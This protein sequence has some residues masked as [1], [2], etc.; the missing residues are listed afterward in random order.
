MS[1]EQE[2]A[3]IETTTKNQAPK[4]KRQL[5]MMVLVALLGLAVIGVLVWREYAAK[6]ISTDNAKVA[7]EIIDVS[8]KVT[9]RLD[10]ILV[11][12][13]QHVEKGQVLAEL[14]LV[15]LKLA[16]EQSEAALDQAKA[17]YEKLPDDLKSADAAV[18][19]AR[20]TVDYYQGLANNSEIALA[21]AERSFKLNEELYNSG[22]LSKDG[23]DSSR[24]KLDSA[25]AKLDSD[26][27]NTRSAQAALDDATA[28]NDLAQRTADKIY[29]AQLKKAQADYDVAKYNYDNA[30]IKAPCSG[31]VVRIAVQVGENI[32][33]SAASYQTILNICDLE[34]TYVTAN[35]EEKEIA[36]I[37]PGQTVDITLDAY[38]GKK[39]AGKVESV[40]GVAQSVF[41][42]IPTESTSGN[43]TKVTQRLPVKIIPESADL[44][45]RP[46]MSAVVK[47]HTTN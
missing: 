47:I 18:V 23:F 29:Q 14:D 8:S 3:D 39:F 15:P 20:E 19:K 9:G 30:I 6:Y 26:L 21:E 4:N 44:V 40:G 34:N 33:S 1:K 38:P 13:E 36:R 11:K 25:R 27:A 7:G 35:V 31:T 24:A 45:F 28:K 12:E 46:G 5:G 16:L 32:T 37:Y 17:N 22:A 2:T 43:Y 41:S 42:L 10:K